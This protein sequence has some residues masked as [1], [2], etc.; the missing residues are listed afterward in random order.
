MSFAEQLADI[1]IKRAKVIQDYKMQQVREFMQ[2]KEKRETE[3]L[4]EKYM[5]FEY[6]DFK[7]DFPE[8]GK[9]KEV[10]ER[11]LGEMTNPDSKYLPYKTPEYFESQYERHFDSLAAMADG[12]YSVSEPPPR[13]HFSGLQF[14]VWN[15]SAFTVKFTW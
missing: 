5:N 1:S 14:D 10:C 15:N 2:A 3:L 13:D 12:Q 9:P 7:A 4:R 8:L 6:N 11:W